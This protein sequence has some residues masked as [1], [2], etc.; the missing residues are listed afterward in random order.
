MTRR[1]VLVLAG[2]FLVTPAALS[3]IVHRSSSGAIATRPDYANV[4]MFL[5]QNFVPGYTNNDGNVVVTPE[6]DVMGALNASI[7]AW[8]SIPTTAAQFAPIQTTMQ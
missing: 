3:Y 1:I 4:Q 2:A 5:N 7:A 8:N 6:S